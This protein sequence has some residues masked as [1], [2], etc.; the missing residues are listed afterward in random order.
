[1]TP[2]LPRIDQ[3]MAQ[4]LQY[5]I[6]SHFPNL[7]NKLFIFPRRWLVPNGRKTKQKFIYVPLLVSCGRYHHISHQCDIAP[8]T[9]ASND[10][11]KPS[12]IIENIVLKLNNGAASDH[13]D[14]VEDAAAV[15]CNRNG[16]GRVI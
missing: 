13:P 5:Y 6:G 3:A 14:R 8:Q 1:M 2:Q 4:M 15:L 7:S 9:E 12:F 16:T 10:T 11:S